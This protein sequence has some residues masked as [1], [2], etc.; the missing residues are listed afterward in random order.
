M[1]RFLPRGGVWL[2]LALALAGCSGGQQAAS[3]PSE[4]VHTGTAEETAHIPAAAAERSGIHSEAAGPGVLR[5]ELEVPGVLAALPGRSAVV[6]ARFPGPVRAL[7]V[8]EGDA[9]HAGQALAVIESNLSLSRYTVHAPLGGV[10]IARHATV[11]AAAAEGTPLYEIADLSELQLDLALFGRDAQA[12][13]AGTAVRIALSSGGE[14]RT[15]VERLLPGV[16]AA[17]QSVTARARVDNPGGTL[18]P[19]MVVRARLVL[20]ERDAPLVLPRNAV[21][22]HEGHTVVFVREGDAY[23]PRPVRT[24]ASDST[25]VEIL[26]GV[27]QGEQVVTEGSWIVLSELGKDGAAHE[28]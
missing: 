26:A 14:A 22:E 24:G 28:H 10:V 2:A 17:S 1:T 3:G 6:A 16:A 19:G 13:T 20:A 18:R 27:Q 15:R 5:E 25:G 23:R 8:E 4:S 7:H 21:Q 11:G 9:V 12:V